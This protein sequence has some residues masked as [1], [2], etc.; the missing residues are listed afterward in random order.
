M[1]ELTEGVI[2][3]GLGGDAVSGGTG[4]EG[5][6][7]EP[8]ASELTGLLGSKRKQTFVT[9]DEKYNKKKKKERKESCHEVA[10]I[11]LSPA[12]RYGEERDV[13]GAALLLCSDGGL[14]R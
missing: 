7:D 2:C 14:E 12:N 4:C 13:L 1:S 11:F 5:A 6:D 10:R 8:G 3:G 9:Q